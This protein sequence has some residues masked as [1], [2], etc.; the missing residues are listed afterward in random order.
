MFTLSHR[1]STHLNLE[2]IYK[3]FAPPTHYVFCHFTSPLELQR[4]RVEDKII[5][6]FHGK[7]KL[8]SLGQSGRSRN[9]ES[10]LSPL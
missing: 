2:R 5:M 7:L 10:R 1:G 4:Q 6:Q 8:F 9:E 3:G